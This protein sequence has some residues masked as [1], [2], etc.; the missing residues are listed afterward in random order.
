MLYKDKDDNFYGYKKEGT[1]P[2]T[3]EYYDDVMVRKRA[4]H[5]ATDEYKLAECERYLASTDW[6]TCR[7]AETGKDM[8]SDVREKRQECRELLSANKKG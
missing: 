1:W 6:Y 3:K 4:E 5:K 7:L 8:P 2:T